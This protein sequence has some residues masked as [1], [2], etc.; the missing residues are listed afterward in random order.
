MK[1]S[2]DE[3]LK[4]SLLRHDH[5][6]AERLS[7]RTP[8]RVLEQLDPFLP[9]GWPGPGKPEG[10]HLQQGAGPSERDSPPERLQHRAR[11]PV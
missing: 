7:L 6:L 8:L 4:A 10:R 3:S 5:F 9:R 11:W 2:S 1:R